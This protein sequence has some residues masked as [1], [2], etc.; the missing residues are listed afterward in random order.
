[1]TDRS[2]AIQRTVSVVEKIKYK[3]D[4]N[5]NDNATDVTPRAVVATRDK[6]PWGVALYSRNSDAT[7]KKKS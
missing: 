7:V 5:S 3:N 1:M 2:R 6:R 4:N